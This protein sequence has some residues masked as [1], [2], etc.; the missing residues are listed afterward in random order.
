MPKSCRKP[1]WKLK[2]CDIIKPRVFTH[3]VQYLVIPEDGAVQQPAQEL[4][5]KVS[6]EVFDRFRT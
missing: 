2:K 3:E 5:N 1:F 4:A 6:L